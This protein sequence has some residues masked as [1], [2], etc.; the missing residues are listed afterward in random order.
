MIGDFSTKPNDVREQQDP[1]YRVDWRRNG[2][3]RPNVPATHSGHPFC[4][5]ACLLALLKNSTD[6]NCPNCPN[7]VHH[8]PNPNIDIIIDEAIYELRYDQID[9]LGGGNHSET[10]SIRTPTGY[11]LAVKAYNEATR[12]DPDYPVRDPFYNELEVYHHLRDLQGVCVP[13]VL[14]G[15]EAIFAG[16]MRHVIFMSFEGMSVARCE[17]TD[18]LLEGIER[19]FAAIHAECVHHDDVTLANVLINGDKVSVIDFESAR[20]CDEGAPLLEGKQEVVERACER[21]RRS[22]ENSRFLNAY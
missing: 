18:S 11:T 13:V 14:C 4:T 19:A 12:P 3:L 6:L 2:P 22:A 16:T 9:L 5:S 20:I 1:P 10:L 7:F 8:P 17:L 15:D 21:V